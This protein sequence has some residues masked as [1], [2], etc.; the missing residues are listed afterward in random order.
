VKPASPAGH[1]RKH[2]RLSPRMVGAAKALE[3][4]PPCHG[5]LAFSTWN[6]AAR[7][8]RRI[9]ATDGY[10]MRAYHCRSC[11]RFHVGANVLGDH[12]R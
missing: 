3:G 5:K 11:H 10:R 4:V 7:V 1:H 9:R 12:D 2:R 8:A 6:A